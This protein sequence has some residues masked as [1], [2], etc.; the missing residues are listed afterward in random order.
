MYYCR[1]TGTCATIEFGF[2]IR[3]K[4]PQSETVSKLAKALVA[5]QSAFKPIPKSKTGQEGNRKFKYADLADVVS[6]VTPIL[7]SNGIFL[8]SQSWLMEVGL[9]DKQ[10]D[11]NSKTSLFR[12]MEL[13]YQTIRRER[14]LV[15]L[16][17]MLDALI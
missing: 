4:M 5:A 7:N 6:M 2:N 14:I 3:R 8:I 13:S 15:S 1:C 11:F 10:L 16:L 12:Q 9:L 17:P